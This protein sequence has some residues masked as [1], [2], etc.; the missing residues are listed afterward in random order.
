MNPNTASRA[1]LASALCWF[2]AANVL[3][4]LFVFRG[5]L[6]GGALLAPLDIPPALFT[7][8]RHVL[9]AQ[10]PVPANHY[11]IDGIYYD[12][13][14]QKTIHEAYR[15]GEMP[16]W[17]PYSFAGRPLLADAHINGTDWVR[18]LCDRLLPFEAAYNWTRILHFFISGLGM[19]LLLRAF[20]FESSLDHADR[21]PGAH[22]AGQARRC[23]PGLAAAADDGDA[24]QGRLAHAT[25][26]ASQK[27]SM[28]A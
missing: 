6:W 17:D 7:Q 26:L 22:G 8:Y 18:V 2:A 4:L 27:L 20:G 5:A 25:A 28:K 3:L 10:P 13:P 9:P 21:R 12:L 14:L 16:W 23:H 19:L 1:P 15:S 24:T 11:I